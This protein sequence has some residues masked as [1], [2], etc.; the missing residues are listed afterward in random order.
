MDE[1]HPGEPP[2]PTQPHPKTKNNPK[3]QTQKQKPPGKPRA[4]PPPDPRQTQNR[5]T[6]HKAT[7]GALERQKKGEE[8]GK[9]AK[10]EAGREKTG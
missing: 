9:G 5:G 7:G 8:P 4:S 1:A 10:R 2:N 3:P 6:A